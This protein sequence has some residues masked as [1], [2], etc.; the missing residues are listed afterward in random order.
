MRRLKEPS[1]NSIYSCGRKSKDSTCPKR[2]SGCEG[3]RE[4][5]SKIETVLIDFGVDKKSTLSVEQ[6]WRVK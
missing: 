4:G 3:G 1:V 6:R 5:T 2:A